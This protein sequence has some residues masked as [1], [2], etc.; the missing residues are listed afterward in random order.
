MKNAAVMRCEGRGQ[1]G[2]GEKYFPAAR[3]SSLACWWTKLMVLHHFL[4]SRADRV[5]P[6][7]LRA[8]WGSTRQLGDEP[9]A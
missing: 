4:A 5:C 1:G 6:H 8:M 3:S 9:S 7:L 2:H